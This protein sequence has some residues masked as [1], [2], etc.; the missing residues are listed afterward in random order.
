MFWLLF[1]VI[2][3]GVADI[4]SLEEPP[5][6][7]FVSGVS[8]DNDATLVVDRL[9]RTA[10]VMTAASLR[11][12]LSDGSAPVDE[13]IAELMNVGGT[14]F[15]SLEN[16]DISKVNS[17]VDGLK[18]ATFDASTNSLS[19]AITDMSKMRD[20]WKS[21]GSLKDIPDEATY[22]T[23]SETIKK[24]DTS[25]LTTTITNI[26]DL[27]NDQKID[28]LKKLLTE[29]EKTKKMADYEKISEVLNSMNVYS[30]I[31][32]LLSLSKTSQMK[33]DKYP[34]S[35]KS[36]IAS[37]LDLL[38]KLSSSDKVFQAIVNVVS[39][40][41][42][43]RPFKRNYTSG[44]IN[45]FE[46]L[47]KMAIDIKDPWM[48][49]QMHPG[50]KIDVI[51]DLSQLSDPMNSLRSQWRKVSTPTLFENVNRVLGLHS[52]LFQG[53]SSKT[54]E[55]LTSVIQWSTS[56]NMPDLDDVYGTSISRLFLKVQKVRRKIDA[57]IS[58]HS[59]SNEIKDITGSASID[60]R[61]LKKILVVLQTQQDI[62]EEGGALRKA[63]IEVVSASQITHLKS[64]S[65][66]GN[67]EAALKCLSNENKEFEEWRRRVNVVNRVKD[68]QNSPA[69]LDSVKQGVNAL[70]KEFG[71]LASIR[72]SIE[73]MKENGDLEALKTLKDL[74]KSIKVFGESV[75]A[76]DLAKKLVERSDHF[77]SF[78]VDGN[79]FEAEFPSEFGF[80]EDIVKEINTFFSGLKGWLNQMKIDGNAKLA[81]FSSL[82]A[83]LNKINSLSLRKEET[84][85]AINEI[86]NSQKDQKTRRFLENFESSLSE[87]SRLDLEFSRFE[88]SIKAMPQ[89][90]KDVS[91]FLAEEHSSTSS[92]GQW[93][94][95]NS[96]FI[97]VALF[98]LLLVFVVL[99][100]IMLCFPE[101][102]KT[103]QGFAAKVKCCRKKNH[104][105]SA[106]PQSTPGKTTSKDKERTASK[107]G[108]PGT[109]ASPAV[110]TPG[111]A[112]V[113]SAPPR[114]GNGNRPTGTASEIDGRDAA[115][116]GSGD[117]ASIVFGA[118][119]PEILA[120]GNP[121]A[122][123]RDSSVVE[124]P[125]AAVNGESRQPGM[126]TADHT[127]GA[128]TIEDAKS[129]VFDKEK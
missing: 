48:V 65:N 25:V 26:I 64:D 51:T 11:T 76:I 61:K 42:E 12:S 119:P 74:D 38:S 49:E 73:K 127:V 1:S 108:R 113:S 62:L 125:V 20:L 118:P 39:L 107:D 101:Q 87:L 19:D 40:E 21:I 18:G 27:N 17:F 13:V 34:D 95:D 86:K 14:D 58:I 4:S 123:S 45:G 75:Y 24:I 79:T 91:S 32:Q 112:D 35:V 52:I 116:T 115:S 57:L 105:G 54:E 30:M 71:P 124:P 122:T 44:F 33:E 46:D 117:T 104:P 59:L 10:R 110:S 63:D 36:A 16:M 128:P 93:L 66:F 100:V 78:V 109:S 50:T 97:I 88:S 53:G 68:L 106:T 83:K 23:L 2:C 47:E 81:D 92:I 121:L 5:Q 22:K 103:L 72:S 126:D 67:F 3:I 94:S 84:K 85:D 37:N 70:S 120:R 98:V 41:Y 9:S 8:S 6:L 77:E 99:L 60:N 129:T 80:F 7:T 55:S 96:L 28:E 31:S 89:A 29:I 102:A 82:F 69:V 111:I 90:I 43:S 114:R 15:K 56:C